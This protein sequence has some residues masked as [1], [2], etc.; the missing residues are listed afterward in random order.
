VSRVATRVRGVL[1]S[2]FIRHGAIVFVASMTVNV[3][4]YIFHFATSRRLGVV[5][6]GELSALNAAFMLSLV[7]PQIGSTIAIKYAASFH[8]VSDAAR[9]ATLIRKFVRFTI[10]GGLGAFVVLLL[11]ALPIASFLRV[12]DPIAVVFTMLMVALSM[13]S[14]TLRGLFQGVE[15]FNSYALSYVLESTLKLVCGVGLV[16][17]GYGVAGAF[18]GWAFGSFAAV[19]YTVIVLERTLGRGAGAALDLHL[20]TLARTLSGVAIATVL[21]AIVQN[22]DLLVVKH[23]ADPT[24]AGLYGAL[25]LAGKI[26][27]FL[28]QFVPL[29]VL[30]K[31]TR[32]ALAGKPAGGLLLQALAVSA[33][34]SLPGLVFYFFFPRLVITTL[35]GKAF[36]GGA[37][38]VFSYGVAMVELAFL[39]VIVNF[40]MGIH[41]FD[42][43]WPLGICAVLE[44]IGIT[45]FHRTLGDVTAVLIAGNL[46]ATLSV[47]WRVW[48][49]T[50]VAAGAGFV[51]L[52][53]AV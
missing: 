4:G 24:T 53:D 27:L 3:L 21:I 33:A 1:A 5:G 50:P 36:A 42:F 45:Q 7:V 51:F 18:A 31:A 46:L 40:K 38:Y 11:L 6:Y 47:S 22:G 14:G 23:V 37:P 19:V 26:L 30:P 29:I 2:D 52:D 49:A 43:A 12:D 35:A 17:A 41:R 39:S 16:Y 9:L 32:T 25:S 8:T 34:M 48:Q 44:V 15:A 28:V 10:V 13:M 20:G